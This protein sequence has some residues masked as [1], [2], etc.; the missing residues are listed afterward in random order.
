MRANKSKERRIE[1]FD[2]QPGR[3]LAGKYEV[4]SRLGAGWE[5]EV[6]KVREINMGIVRAAKFF[7]PHR[8]PRDRNANFYAKKLHKLRFCDILIQY[9]THETIQY[10]RTPITFLVSDYVEGELL[11]ELLKRQPGKRL[12]VFEGLHLLHRLSSGIECI[13]LL[14]DYHGDLHDENIIVNRFGL[15]FEVKL[16]DLFH[17]GAPKASNIHQDVCDLIRVFYDVIGGAK[18]YARHPPVVKEICCGLKRTLILQKFRTAGQLR[19]HLETLD[20]D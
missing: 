10:K 2:F 4:L 5:G 11:C 14:G 9:H 17:W 15:G 18:H 6:F 20:W 13:H 1:A 3:V 16:V 19:E 7:Y 8:N 12:T